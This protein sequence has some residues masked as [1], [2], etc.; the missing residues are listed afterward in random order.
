L[1]HASKAIEAH[2]TRPS[3][4]RPSVVAGRD[5]SGRPIDGFDAQIAAICLAEGSMLATRN[6]KDFEGT[7]VT[8]TDPWAR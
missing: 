4:G 2:F 5:R 1:H 7:G 3:E 6:L 8:L